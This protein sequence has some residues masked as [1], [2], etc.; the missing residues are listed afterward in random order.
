MFS[1]GSKQLVRLMAGTALVLAVSIAPAAAATIVFDFT[2]SG[3]AGTI[4]NSKVFTLGGVTITA[5]AWSYGTN[6]QPA[7]VGQ[8]SH[9][10]GVCG[11]AELSAGCT[12][13][14]HEIDNAGGLVDFVLFQFSGP[15]SVDPLS[16][17]IQTTSNDDIDASYWTGVLTLPADRLKDD[18]YADL[19]TR[20]F[21]ARLDNDFVHTNST[22]DFRT[23]T[24]TSGA[25]T[26]LLF[27]ARYGQYDDAFKITSMTVTTIPS[28]PEPAS[29]ML[30]GSGLVGLA[31]RFRRRRA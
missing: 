27:G 6:F 25:V 24:L 29:M 16:V 4:G 22:D 10:L 28:V 15:V 26:G 12:S 19:A 9:G 23:V 17:Y 3:G 1:I 5:T 7:A 11:S 30:L 18:T 20:G 2:G 13:P 14:N 8:Y 21:G 31:A